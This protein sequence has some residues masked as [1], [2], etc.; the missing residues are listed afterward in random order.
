MSFTFRFAD[1]S[2]RLIGIGKEAGAR[3]LRKAAFE[4]R[5]AMRRSIRKSKAW[6]AKGQPPH[7]RRGALRNAILYDVD[8]GKGIAVVGPAAH[9]FSNVASFH[10]H[11]GVQ[12]KKGKRRVYAPGKSGPIDLRG[13][14]KSY[15]KQGIVFAKL[16]TEAQARRA[17]DIDLIAWPDTGRPKARHYPKRPFAG[18]ALERTAPRLPKIWEDAF[19]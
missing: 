3:G 15:I 11:G 18:P 10:E 1:E 12:L 7:T 9:L 2:H 8:T 13:G 19:K 4:T 14:D 6:S 16:K 17:R 5:K